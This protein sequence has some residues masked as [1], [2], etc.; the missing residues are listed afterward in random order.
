MGQ[1]ITDVANSFAMGEISPR[2][3]GRVDS[4]IYANAARELFNVVILTEAGVTR[5]PGFKAIRETKTGTTLLRLWSFES[6][7]EIW[8]DIE[9]GDEYSRFSSNGEALR[10]TSGA[11]EV[12]TPWTGVEL[13][14]LRFKEIYK[15][16]CSC[17]SVCGPLKNSII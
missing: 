17:P 10:N 7:R 4:P 15:K 14:S 16:F 5:R 1:E 12:A 13:A 11:I 6:L 8:V 2:F 9:I 3:L